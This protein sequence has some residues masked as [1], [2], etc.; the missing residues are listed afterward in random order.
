[1]EE[2]N[3]TELIMAQY[4]NVFGVD[5]KILEHNRSYNLVTSKNYVILSRAELSDMLDYLSDKINNSHL[6]LIDKTK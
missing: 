1:M 3:K 4:N 5:L 2:A 6:Y